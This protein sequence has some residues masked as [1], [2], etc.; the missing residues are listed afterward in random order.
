MNHL[1]LSEP[2]LGTF[3]VRCIFPQTN[4]FLRPK[5]ENLLLRT[6]KKKM[7]EYTSLERFDFTK[8]YIITL[9]PYNVAM[10]VLVQ[11]KTTSH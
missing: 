9:Y 7:M 2:T 4:A 5:L 8:R 10:A 3:T 1:S 6:N 11:E